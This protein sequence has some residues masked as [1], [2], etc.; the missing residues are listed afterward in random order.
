[1]LPPWKFT[2]LLVAATPI[3]DL[4]SFEQCSAFHPTIAILTAPTDII[5]RAGTASN[6][7]NMSDRPLSGRPLPSSFDD[8]E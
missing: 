3:A 7:I 8:N 5:S 6:K 2:P 4:S 1:M